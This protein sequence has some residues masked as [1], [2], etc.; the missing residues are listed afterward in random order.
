M[1]RAA[2]APY[3]APHAPG[4]LDSA[5]VLLA[6]QHVASMHRGSGSVWRKTSVPGRVG[7]SARQHMT[8]PFDAS[9][10]TRRGASESSPSVAGDPCNVYEAA[11]A[12]GGAGGGEA[13]GVDTGSV[14]AA[15]SI[16]FTDRYAV[17]APRRARTG[18]NR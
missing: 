16:H 18:R 5:D 11:R 15:A 13:A 9:A 7:A 8:S 6:V 14:C 10:S 17:V 12:I 4:P 3:R 2:P 1:P